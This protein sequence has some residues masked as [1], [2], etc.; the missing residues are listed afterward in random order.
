MFSIGLD[1]AVTAIGA[2][3]SDNI[4]G[5]T[6]FV[7]AP[8]RRLALRRAVLS[9]RRTGTALRHLQFTLNVI[10]ALTPARGA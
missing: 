3:Q 1:I 8:P 5:Q 7:G 10:D 9:E 6:R 4:S 2:R